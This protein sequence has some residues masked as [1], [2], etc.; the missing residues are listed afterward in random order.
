MTIGGKML[1]SYAY[2]ALNQLETQTYGNQDFV[3]FE[4]DTMGRVTK[5][6]YEDGETV[7]YVYDSIG[8]LA[9][10]TDSATGV[11][12]TYYYDLLNRQ[13]G[14]WE[15][16]ESLDHR[17]IYAYNEDNQISSITETINGVTSTHTYSYN[18]DKRL[19]SE[20]ANGITVNY[21]YD[22]FGRLTQKQTVKNGT[23]VKTDTYTFTTKK[24]WAQLLV[25]QVVLALL[26]LGENITLSSTKRTVKYIM[27]SHSLLPM[28]F[29]LPLLRL[30]VRWEIP[31]LPALMYTMWQSALLNG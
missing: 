20:N 18:E 11:V 4:Y 26:Q 10:V 9:T 22:D 2:N 17:V 8:N 13:V 19:I 15:K 14:Y 31:G 7:S 30:M 23:V 21:T 5:Q 12:T 27:G 3:C 6:T 25:H 28:V 29:I 16:S 1:V 24:V